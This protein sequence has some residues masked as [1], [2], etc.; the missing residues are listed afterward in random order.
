MVI[1]ISS[2]RSRVTSSDRSTD[3]NMTGAPQL[4]SNGAKT[5]KK[6]NP[7]RAVIP[8]ATRP[9]N[10]PGASHHPPFFSLVCSPP[11]NLIWHLYL[12][13]MS[14]CRRPCRQRRRIRGSPPREA[15]ASG[16]KSSS[17]SP[18]STMSVSSR[19]WRR[20]PT[21]LDGAK[22]CAHNVSHRAW[23]RYH[24]NRNEVWRR[25]AALGRSTLCLRTST[26]HLCC[27]PEE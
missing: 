3:E 19:G 23:Q 22:V 11:I 5:E 20:S 4:P 21:L 10:R 12:G 25:R 13:R 8:N 17:S 2:L 27:S 26:D 1:T 15:R 14:C 24:R 16:W 6:W 18:P 7:P 9:S